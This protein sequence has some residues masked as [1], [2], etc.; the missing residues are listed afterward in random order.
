V[1]Q[2]Y[3]G[4]PFGSA[5]SGRQLRLVMSTV[6][7]LIARA[8]DVRKYELRLPPD[9]PWI[10]K[11]RYDI[12]AEAPK[13]VSPSDLQR[14]LGPLLEER[15]RLKWHREKREAPAYFLAAA[16]GGIKLTPTAPGACAPWA[17]HRYPPPHPD[18]SQRPTCDYPL[19]PV[20]PDGRGLSLLGTGV[21]MR[22]VVNRLTDLLGRNVI[23]R[24]GFTR[25]FDLRMQ[26]ER[27]TAV[28]SRTPSGYPSLFT[29]VRALGLN[30]EAGKAPMDVL[31]VDSVLQ[32]SGN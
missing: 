20:T 4:P 15:F 1:H 25:P 21:T 28:E 3:C 18:P 22:S 17:D 29:A 24:T 5:I 23:D 9:Q 30:L 7:D 10:S 27:E 8:W 13:P 26:F 11:L 19:M 12:T 2:T 14:M 16:K 32:P 31:V 6:H